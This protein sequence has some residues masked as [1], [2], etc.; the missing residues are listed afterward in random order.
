M[1]LDLKP[2]DEVITPSFT[3]I[4]TVEVIHLL[5]MTPV[6]VDVD[7]CTFTLDP[8]AVAKAV[9]PRKPRPSCRS[10]STASVPT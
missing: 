7:P 1:A 6:M 8:A 9:T 5:R 4:S 2:G 3:F 10:T